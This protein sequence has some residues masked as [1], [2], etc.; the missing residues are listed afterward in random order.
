MTNWFIK[1]KERIFIRL[2]NYFIR[3]GN[4]SFI[5]NTLWDVSKDIYYEDN[6]ATRY[7]HLDA[8]LKNTARRKGKYVS[9]HPL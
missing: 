3:K 4:I 1:R 7:D 2:L 5:F 6:D 9:S 8:L